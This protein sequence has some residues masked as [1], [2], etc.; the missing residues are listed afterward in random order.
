LPAEAALQFQQCVVQQ[1]RPEVLAPPADA[2]KKKK[3]LVGEGAASLM[4]LQGLDESTLKA[5]DKK[6]RVKSLE[7]CS[8]V[9]S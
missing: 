5:L 4:Q 1:V 2:A 3:N 9:I 8:L 6:H 7:V